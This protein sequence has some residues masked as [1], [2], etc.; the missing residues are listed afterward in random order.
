[1]KIFWRA[2]GEKFP[3]YFPIYTTIQVDCGRKYCFK[4]FRLLKL[5]TALK[6]KVTSKIIEKWKSNSDEKKLFESKR[7]PSFDWIRQILDV[8][9]N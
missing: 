6:H 2:N 5:P 9:K 1:M 8:G 3:I 4:E 7:N